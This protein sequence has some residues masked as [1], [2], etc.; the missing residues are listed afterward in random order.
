MEG[1]KYVTVLVC[2]AVES[3][4]QRRVEERF[5]QAVSDGRKDVLEDIVSHLLLFNFDSILPEK[6]KICKQVKH[7]K[8][9][10]HELV[11]LL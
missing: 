10:I 5:L 2:P 4:E 3:C 1:D 9:N 7:T 11:G 6:F 8:L